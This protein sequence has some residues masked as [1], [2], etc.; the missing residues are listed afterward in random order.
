M[1]KTL[2]NGAVFFL[3]CILAGAVAFLYLQNQSLTSQFN[4]LQRGYDHLKVN[5]TELEERL[6]IQ[7]NEAVKA[8][9]IL[10]TKIIPPEGPEL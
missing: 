5:Y 7:E 6:T 8:R 2:I 9:E 10:P 4:E 3:L 1:K